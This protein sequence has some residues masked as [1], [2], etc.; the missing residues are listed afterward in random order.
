[1]RAFLL[2]LLRIAL[3]AAGAAALSLVAFAMAPPPLTAFMVEASF[4]RGSPI[5]YKWEPASRISSSLLVAVVA[6]EDQRFA[7]HSGF[8]WTEI[9]KATHQRTRSGR[10]RGASTISQ[11]VAKNL[12]LWPGHSYLRKAMEALLTV[13]IEAVWT[14]HRI[15]E[16]YV[17][18]AEFGDG[19]FGAQAAALQFFHKHAAELTAPQSALLA[20]SLPNPHDLRVDSPSPSMRRRQASILKQMGAIGGDRWLDRIR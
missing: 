6:A 13:M 17:N 16:V 2:I 12:F 8:D 19:V 10:I 20:A 9:R 3:A 15:L 18:V 7:D 1:M 14:K 4:E 5:H 11:Q